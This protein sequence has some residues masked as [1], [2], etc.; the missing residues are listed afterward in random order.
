MLSVEDAVANLI[1]T[2][3]DT[4]Q[5]DETYVLFTSDNGHHN[6]HRRQ[7]PQKMTAYDED[8]R[9]PLLVRGPGVPAGVHR[10]HLV[11]NN[12]WAPTIAGL[13][14]VDTPGFVDGRSFKRLLRPEPPA[15][16]RW[17]SAFVVEKWGNDITPPYRAVRTRTHLFV[18]Y[19][20]GER[21]LY[22]LREDPYQVRA[23]PPGPTKTRLSR[24]FL[25]RLDA[26]KACARQQCRTQERAAP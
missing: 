3:E 15:S 25:P 19:P 2:L 26:I 20:G 11:V 12:D 17:R 14:G 16:R 4:G 21:E 8:I 13:A 10:R 24:R 9:V 7:M 6:G 1:S 5:L 22:D 18:R 23:L